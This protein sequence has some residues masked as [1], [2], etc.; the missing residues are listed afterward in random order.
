MDEVIRFRVDVE[1]KKL[2]EAEAQKAGLSVSAF[3]RLLVRNW[4]DGIT[5]EK[6]V[7]QNPVRQHRISNGPH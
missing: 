7:P 3:I 2:I 6:T 5:F 4:S 1:E